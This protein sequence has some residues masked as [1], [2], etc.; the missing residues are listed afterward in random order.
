MLL[1]QHVSVRRES[2]WALWE[3]GFDGWALAPRILPFLVLGLLLLRPGLRRALE[4]EMITPLARS[5]FTWAFA[6]ALVVVGVGVALHRPY[7]LLPFRTTAA[8][9]TT[10]PGDWKH[11]GRTLS[12]TRYAP[13]DQITSYTKTCRGVSFYETPGASGE[14]ARRI[15]TATA[16]ARLFAVDANTSLQRR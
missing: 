13:F 16:D 15:L 14:C 5:P 11:F 2:S 7:P 9:T 1:Q 6:A 10:A 12:G 4:P 8:A 3:S